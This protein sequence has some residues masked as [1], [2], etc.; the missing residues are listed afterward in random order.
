MG[1][2][3]WPGRQSG[4][5]DVHGAPT[6]TSRDGSTTPCFQPF[7]PPPGSLLMFESC[8]YLSRIGLVSHGY[9]SNTHS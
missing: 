3:L 4:P 7:S 8:V 9:T 5:H 2:K 6:V 1:V